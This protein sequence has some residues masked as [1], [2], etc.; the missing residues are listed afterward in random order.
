MVEAQTLTTMFGGI[1]VGVAA[2]YYVMM[3]RNN[4]NL[5]K[6]DF[7][8]QKLQAP[9]QFYEAYG[10]VMWTS[11]WKTYEE[12]RQKY[13][14]K[15]D[16]MPKLWYIM[17]HFNALGLLLKEGLATPEQIFQQYLPISILLVY[18][19][20][21]PEI[22]AAHFTPSMEVHNPDA[23]AGFELL[24]SEAKRLY[25]KTPL[26]PFPR[27]VLLDHAKRIDELLKAEK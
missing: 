9:I 22:I 4:E 15:P 8:F 2:F 7:V 12:F 25:P 5:K 6:R 26:G 27:E 3:L 17:N 18:E 24:Y 10:P 1:G 20:Y 16:L 19:K 13:Y 21:K 14:H 11:D 23:Y